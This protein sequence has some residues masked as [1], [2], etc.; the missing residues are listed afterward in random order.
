LVKK[1][2]G[3]PAADFHPETIAALSGTDLIIFQV[4]SPKST[5]AKNG[6]FGPKYCF[7][8]KI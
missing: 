5:F 2:F 4:F 7:I 6:D 8:A 3:N 1:L